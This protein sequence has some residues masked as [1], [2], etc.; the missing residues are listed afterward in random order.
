MVSRVMIQVPIEILPAGHTCD[1]H[2]YELIYDC[3]QPMPMLLMLHIHHSRAADIVVPDQMTTDPSLPITSLSR[4]LR[5]LVQ[6]HHGAGR[7]HSDRQQRR[8]EQQRHARSGTS[9]RPA[10][11]GAGTPEE[12]LVYL[13]GG[14]YCETDLLSETAWRLFKDAPLGWGRVQAICDFVHNHIVFNYANARPPAQPG[15]HSTSEPAF[16]RFGPLPWRC[17]AA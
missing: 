12:T 9:Q 14:R 16:S 6:P 2:G 1:P 11:F 8:A 4:W 15:K 5:Q 7:A 10:A 17:A 3:P 13:L